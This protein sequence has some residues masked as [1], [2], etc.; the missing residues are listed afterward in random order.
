SS[1]AINALKSAILACLI[2][3][4]PTVNKDIKNIVKYPTKTP[5]YPI[6]VMIEASFDLPAANTPSNALVSNSDR[7][8]SA[9][10]LFSPLRLALRNTV[11]R[12]QTAHHAIYA[13]PEAKWM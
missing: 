13:P 10:I 4:K 3:R 12:D 2:S 9:V 1:T 6:N 11:R 7:N 8:A 5:T